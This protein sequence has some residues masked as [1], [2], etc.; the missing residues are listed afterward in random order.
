MDIGVDMSAMFKSLPAG[1]GDNGLGNIKDS[2]DTNTDLK[3]SMEQFGITKFEMDFDTSTYKLTSNMIFKNLEYF[4]KFMNKDRAENLKPIKVGFSTSNFSVKN[5]ASLI[6]DE[7]L[8]GLGDSQKGDEG[9]GDM[10]MSKFFTFKTTYHF[11][12]EVKKFKSAIGKG[13]LSEDQK[14]I[15]FDNTL[16]E[17]TD[18]KYNGDLEVSFK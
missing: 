14:S 16:D 5:C 2:I 18:E 7:M 4:N 12:Y 15:S 11:P 10:D 13:S 17:F 9:M 8:K 1:G 3:D 6:S